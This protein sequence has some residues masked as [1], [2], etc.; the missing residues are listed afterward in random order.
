MFS[1]NSSILRD[2]YKNVN[3]PKKPINEE[4]RLISDIAGAA[5]DAN[6]NPF[7]MSIQKSESLLSWPFVK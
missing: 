6:I 2:K 5:I 1:F 4:K 3:P 7:E